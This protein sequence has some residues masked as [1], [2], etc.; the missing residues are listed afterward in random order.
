MNVHEGWMQIHHQL[1]SWCRSHNH[2]LNVRQTKETQV[3]Q[4]RT[5]VLW[6]SMALLWRGSAVSSSLRVHLVDD[7]SSIINTTTIIKLAQQHLHPL[8]R[9]RKAG[10]PT[11]HLNTFYRDTI[12]SILAYGLISC[13]GSCKKYERHQLNRVVKTAKKIIGTPCYWRATD[14]CICRATAIM[15]DPHD[16]SYRTS[17]M[18]NCFVPQAVRLITLCP[19]P[20]PLSK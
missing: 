7:L 1:T 16:P 14:R 19:L 5:T 9:Q 2:H 3:W 13:F 11:I 10:Y 15:K 17:R 12:E 4:S 18:L 8:W 6:T 20:S